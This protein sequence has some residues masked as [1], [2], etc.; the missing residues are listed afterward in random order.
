MDIDLTQPL[1]SKF[2]IDEEEF[3]VEY[4]NLSD[5][6]ICCGMYGHLHANC[7]HKSADKE[8]VL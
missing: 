5:L 2:M 6:C 4:E 3:T 8:D 7:A 1:V